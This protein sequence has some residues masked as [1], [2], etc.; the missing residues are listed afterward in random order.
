MEKNIVLVGFMATGKSMVGR[1]VAKKMGRQFVDIDKEIV[2]NSKMSISEIFEKYGEDRFRAMESEAIEKF[3]SEKN[4]VIATG[5]GALIRERNVNSL[6]KNGVLIC[7]TAS[8]KEILKRVGTD[9]NRPILNVEDKV[10]TIAR[11]LDE[12]MRYY[13][14]AD[15]SLDSEIGD[16]DEIAGNVIKAFLEFTKYGKN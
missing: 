6:K 1:A 11:K 7:L 12:R 13:A 9:T 5:G 10:L 16:V 4:L 2:I 8:T 14:L 3:S 15:I